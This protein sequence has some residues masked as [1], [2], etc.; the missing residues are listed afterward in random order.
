MDG[1]TVNG[2]NEEEQRWEDTALW[3]PWRGDRDVV[4][5]VV[6]QHPLC[7]FGQE[8]C[9]L[10]DQLVVQVEAGGEFLC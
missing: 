4:E 10:L 6:D 8:V 3:G 2:V 5:D 1:P 9:N 7:P